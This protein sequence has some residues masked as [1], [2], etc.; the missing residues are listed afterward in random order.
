MV[1]AANHYWRGPPAPAFQPRDWIVVGDFNRFEQDPRLPPTLGAAL[2]IG[3]EQSPH[4]NVLSVLAMQDTLERMGRP[5]K[6]RVDL[7]LGSEIALRQ[8]ARVLLLPSI[9]GL[10][11]HPHIR[12]QVVDPA[13]RRVLFVEDEHGEG[14][15]S[16]LATLDAATRR[17]R[18]RLGE[19]LT[20]IRGHGK[21]MAQVTTTDIEALRSFVQAD[22]AYRKGADR[23]ALEL[24]DK[25]LARDPA[26][27]MAQVGSAR[28]HARSGD[29][30]RALALAQA[31]SRNRTRLSHPE[32]L[33]LD[34][35]LAR[36]GPPGPAMAR[37][38][39]WATL[40]PDA[41][42]AHYG[43]ALVALSDNRY[44]DALQGVAPALSTRNPRQGN[45]WYLRGAIL[46]ALNRYPAAKAAFDRADALGVGGEK[47]ESA[48]VFAAE[49]DFRTAE[50]RLLRQ[51]PSGLAGSDLRRRLSNPVLL[52]D[53]GRWAEALV[54]LERLQA[55]ATTAAPLQARAL[56]ATRLS[57]DAYLGQS[58]PARYRRFVD[59]AAARLA[60]ADPVARDQA[61]FLLLAGGWMATH[62]GDAETGRRALALGSD[63]V[64]ANGSALLL[65]IQAILG[66]ELALAE[67]RPDL[68]AR[69]LRARHDGSELYFSH[70]V[71]LRA[72]A[73]AGENDAALAEAAWLA[74]ERGRAYAEWNSLDAWNAANI[75]ESHLARL[76]A[77]ELALKLNRPAEARRQA[78]QFLRDWPGAAALPPF[79]A[80]LEPL[81]R[82]RELAD[83][84]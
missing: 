8:G 44:L 47:L 27:A 70:A 29:Y 50:A 67:G 71:L 80:R 22:A 23:L 75:V 73:A 42:R 81:Q 21:P 38:K 62:A 59:E 17:V 83:E 25:A 32:A 12:L 66:A 2:R 41:Y 52:V 76:S 5:P 78:E 46:L 74:R 16:A 4:L 30:P 10:P 82:A 45:A 33:E 63:P 26:F 37:F 11:G 79:R 31:A 9:D 53:Q 1:W 36:F 48:E 39:V 35:F 72:L 58:D 61:A 56:Q 57:L 15:D 19:S 84:S 34:T 68:A 77:A 64:R 55:E 20:G 3:L 13:S 28:V 43:Y 69:L 40:Y 49:R 7:L 6:S 54:S 51:T 60:E 14:A 65:G 24:Y 18:A